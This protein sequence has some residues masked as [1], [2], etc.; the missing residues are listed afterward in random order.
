M[1]QCGSVVAEDYFDQPSS[2][3]SVNSSMREN[4]SFDD[5]LEQENTIEFAPPEGLTAELI[6]DTH[7]G[8]NINIPL[9]DALQ[10][11]APNEIDP[12]VLHGFWSTELEGATI[13]LDLNLGNRVGSASGTT[14]SGLGLHQGVAISDPTV[15]GSLKNAGNLQ[16]LPVDV[17]MAAFA[18]LIMRHTGERDILLG[19]AP[20]QALRCP[21][22]AAHGERASDWVLVRNE[23]AHVTAVGQLHVTWVDGG[24]GQ[25]ARARLRGTRMRVL[26]NQGMRLAEIA[27]LIGATADMIQ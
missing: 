3:N 27:D 1:G 2:S 25:A 15:L 6:V 7:A 14:L 12:P 21:W 18:V 4:K 5:F 17:F 8:D 24:V 13:S 9:G 22:R 16:M 20:T 19:V 10:L 23:A 26:E 11:H